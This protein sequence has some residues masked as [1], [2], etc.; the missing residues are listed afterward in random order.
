MLV[1]FMEQ[2]SLLEK[3]KVIDSTYFGIKPQN[4]NENVDFSKYDFR[5]IYRHLTFASNKSP[6]LISNIILFMDV[7]DHL[8]EQ[9]I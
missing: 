4:Q 2:A 8:H 7:F 9:Y 3:N 6:S 5:P 1:S